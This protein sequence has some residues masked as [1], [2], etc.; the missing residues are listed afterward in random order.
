MHGPRIALVTAFL[1]LA[2]SP[3]A[4]AREYQGGS[5]Y[6]LTVPDDWTQVSISGVDVAFI[7]PS[8]QGFGANLNVVVFSDPSARNTPEW[9]LQ[10]AQVTYPQ[11]LSQFPGATGFQPPRSFTSGSGRPAAD[12]VI[13]YDLSGTPLRVR[14]VLFA[15]DPWDRGYILTFTAHRDAYNSHEQ[16]WSTAVDTFTVVDEG[17]AGF[18]IIVIGAI[19][20]A[21]IG[22]TAAVAIVLVRRRK[23]VP[24]A[25]PGELP[26]PPA[27]GPLGWPPQP[28]PPPS[29]PPGVGP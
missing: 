10:T 5:H 15:S 20:G 2:L 25:M 1:L 12:Y 24:P 7:G 16:A 21:A 14:Q 11:V 6:R 19:A 13:N 27:A 26:T 22:G 18:P 9:L 4:E 8:S 3:V 17:A 23:K 29:S 28:P